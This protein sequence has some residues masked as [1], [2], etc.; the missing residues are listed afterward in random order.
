MTLDRLAHKMDAQFDKL[1]RA[2]QQEFQAVRTDVKAE[3]S[4][5]REDV[6]ILRRDLDE[7]FRSVALTLKEVVHE[8]KELRAMDAELTELRIRVKRLEKKLGIAA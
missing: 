6:T 4:A 2:T 3:V 1:A 7:G 5:V 8:M